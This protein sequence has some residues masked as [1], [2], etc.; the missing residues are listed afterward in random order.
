MLRTKYVKV[1][2]EIFVLSAFSKY[3]AGKMK[4]S[5]MSVWSSHSCDIGFTLSLQFVIFTLQLLEVRQPRLFKT[6]LRNGINHP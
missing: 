6:T 1:C 4:G 5:G 2:C 3:I